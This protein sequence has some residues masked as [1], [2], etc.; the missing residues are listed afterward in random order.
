ML[1]GF[2]QGDTSLFLWSREKELLKL[3]SSKMDDHDDRL[4]ATDYHPVLGLYVSG[5]L[6]RYV[7]IFNLKKEL[8]KEIKFPQPVT[9]V[10]FLNARG[11]VIVGHETK[12][13]I[14]LVEDLKLDFIV[15]NNYPLHPKDLDNF[16]KN[17]SNVRGKTFWKLAAIDMH[18][19]E[20]TKLKPKTPIFPGS[21]DKRSKGGGMLP[22]KKRTAS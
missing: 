6:D 8:L 13:S 19:T 9:A 14:V 5:G 2:E 10:C 4:S 1:F 12:V 15:D 22:G 16:Y 11:D 3:H 21:P 17:Y 18:G 20:T 7:R